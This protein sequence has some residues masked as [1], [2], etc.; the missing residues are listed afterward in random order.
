M[1]SA[2]LGENQTNCEQDE[3]KE[4]VVISAS[5]SWSDI[6]KTILQQLSFLLWIIHGPLGAQGTA[7]DALIMKHARTLD[8]NEGHSHSF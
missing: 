7:E 5:K 8:S 4:E 3:S 2:E 6:E 1:D